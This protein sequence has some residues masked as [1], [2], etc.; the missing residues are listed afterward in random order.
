M[1][2]KYRWFI[3]FEREE[4]WLNDNLQKGYTLIAKNMFGVYHFVEMQN[5]MKIL[6][7]DFQR[8][9]SAHNFESYKSQ[10]EEVGWKHIDGKKGNSF[11]YWIKEK[12]GN[13]KIL[14]DKQSFNSVYAKLSSHYA[15]LMLILLC[16]IMFVNQTIDPNPFILNPL[17][18]INYTNLLSMN[19]F[20]FVFFSAWSIVIMIFRVVPIWLLFFIAFMWL[21]QFLKYKKVEKILILDKE[22]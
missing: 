22:K 18:A 6:R 14:S 10:F 16:L 5:S 1:V 12:N 8:I 15:T 9:K 11:H 7:L 2:R 13:D 19:G 3:D 20:E 17:K 4:K 21:K